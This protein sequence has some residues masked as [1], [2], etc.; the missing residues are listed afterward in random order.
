[1]SKA[2]DFYWSDEMVRTTEEIQECSL[3]TG[4]DKFGCIHPPLIRIP[5]CNVVP[6]ELHLMLRITDK[7]EKNLIH[8]ILRRDKLAERGNQRIEKNVYQHKLLQA[9]KKC[10]VTFSIWNKPDENGNL[11]DKYD[12]T[13]LMGADKKPSFTTF[14]THLQNLF[15]QITLKL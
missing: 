1:M 2:K 11:T 8:S 15:P 7:L 13:S 6:D 10:G 12:W 4:G 3:Q 5:L 14:P 9:M